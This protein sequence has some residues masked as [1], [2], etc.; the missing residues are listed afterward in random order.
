VKEKSPFYNLMHMGLV[1]KDM[2]QAIKDFAAF[3]IGP[4]GDP[5]SMDGIPVFRGKQYDAKVKGMVVH[6]GDVEFEVNQPVEG[7]TP[8]QEFFEST[9]GG[10]HHVGFLVDDLK[11]A[12]DYLTSRGF[13]VMLSG[14]GPTEQWNYFDMKASGLIFQLTQRKS[15]EKK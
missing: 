1:V 8:Q 9:G 5:P 15:P 11:K 2:D 3:G 13:E 6:L 4:F 14:G 7:H 12:T 10:L